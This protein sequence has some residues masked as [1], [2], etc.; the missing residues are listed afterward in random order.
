M[1][2]PPCFG[3]CEP[4]QTQQLRKRLFLVHSVEAVLSVEIT[5]EAPRISNYDETASNEKLEDDVDA[6]D[7]ARDVALARSMQYQKNLQNYH[8]HQVRP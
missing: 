2:Y 4:L 8:S 6:L 7:N 1:S 5:R 3:V